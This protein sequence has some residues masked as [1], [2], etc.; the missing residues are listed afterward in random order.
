LTGE[1]PRIGSGLV[2]F[3]PEGTAHPGDKCRVFVRVRTQPMVEVSDVKR[4]A[5]LPRDLGQ[6]ARQRDRIRPS[7]NR[8]HDGFSPVEHLVPADGVP[9]AADEVMVCIC[10]P[11]LTAGHGVHRDFAP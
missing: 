5:D 7:R 10:S 9:D 3:E 11:R 6:T 4:Q 8:R 1:R 2:M